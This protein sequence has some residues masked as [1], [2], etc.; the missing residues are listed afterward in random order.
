MI[1]VSDDATD[2]P[3]N[4]S[5]RPDEEQERARD[6]FDSFD[7][8][9]ERSGDPF[10]SLGD[11]HSDEDNS[12]GHHSADE[13]SADGQSAEDGPRVPDEPSPSGS[14]DGSDP[15]E[16]VD[17]AGTD[18]SRGGERESD[19]TDPRTDGS[20]RSSQIPDRQ[21]HETAGDPLADLDDSRGDPFESNASAFERS[22]VD[23]IDPD[24]V[25]NRLTEEA[26]SEGDTA[27]EAA[28]SEQ[29]S[30]D[31]DVVAVSKH[32]YCEGCEHF[33]P[34]PDVQCSHDGT[35]ILEFVDIDTVK[36]A[37]CPV[38]AERRELDEEV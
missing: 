10:D 17:D 22:D 14:T 16:Y 20:E 11:Q 30:T 29:Q 2:A 37:N 19:R 34:P 33:S 18:P 27:A 21:A 35:E 25:W 32:S 31:D 6:P 13:H 9:S 38:V 3:A 8:Y 5:E 23:G 15:F 1:H 28:S 4:D 24:E 12:T 36:V 7:E 26:R